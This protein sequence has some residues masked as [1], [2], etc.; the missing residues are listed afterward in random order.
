MSAAL[1]A[2]VIDCA[3]PGAL[4]AFYSKLTGWDVAAGNADGAQLS[5][6]GTIQLGFQRI[7]GY[8]SP[9]W[10][11]DGKQ[12]HLDFTVTDVDGATRELLALG[13]D[14]PDFQP[15]GA[16]WTVLTDPEGHPFCL[17]PEDSGADDSSSRSR[18][19]SL[20]RLADD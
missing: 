12:F 2:V 15:G 20:R 6:N 16:D 3:D 13:A 19:F 7:A 14:K 18:P 8:R 1:A 10:P 17:V 9:G 4:A 11:G 5:S